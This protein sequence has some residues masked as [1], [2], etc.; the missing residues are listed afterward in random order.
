[1]SETGPMM[2]RMCT[3]GG[4]KEITQI[5]VLGNGTT[6]GLAGVR[7]AFE[8]LYAAGVAPDER[9]GDELL[10]MIKAGNYVPRPAEPLYK[11]ALVREYAAFC[12]RKSA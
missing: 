4:D 6:I 7:P 1:M 11:A 9:A 5:D 12:R 10:A 3:C 2:G 8:T